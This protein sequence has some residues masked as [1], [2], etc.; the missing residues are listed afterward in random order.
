MAAGFTV[1]ADKIDALQ[2]FLN[3]RLSAD[4]KGA[5]PQTLHK[6]PVDQALLVAGLILPIGLTGLARLAAATLS[7][8]LS[9]PI[10]ESHRR[11]LWARRVCI[12]LA[13]WMMAAAP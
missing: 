10:A 9:F 6:K 3:D 12:Y 4:L 1:R 11:N 7:H 2:Q 5:I 13:G 8:D